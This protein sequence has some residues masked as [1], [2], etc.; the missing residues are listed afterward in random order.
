MCDYSL[1]HVASRSAVV[2]DKLVTTSFGSGTTG[3]ASVDDASTAVCLL[4]G[5]EL[6]FDEDP[7]QAGLTVLGPVVVE[8]NKLPRT[9]RFQQINKDT[10]FVHHDCLD[11]ADGR[12]LLLNYMQPGLHA[13]VLQL[14]AAPK[15]EQ[16]AKDQERVAV[17]A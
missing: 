14:P 7:V 8:Q 6:A 12:S 1:S 13:T 11:F 17:T 16:E 5:T 2:G 10:E 3:F 9:A 4:P 15:N